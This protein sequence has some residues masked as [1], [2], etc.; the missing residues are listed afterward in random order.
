MTD[1]RL[2]RIGLFQA[3]IEQRESIERL[4]KLREIL[5][6]V[7]KFAKIREQQRNSS[8]PEN[9]VYDIHFVRAVEDIDKA[10]LRAGE[11]LGVE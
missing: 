9:G 10:L 11:V 6:P 8:E 2:M 4:N 1:E 7:V 3:A 5:R